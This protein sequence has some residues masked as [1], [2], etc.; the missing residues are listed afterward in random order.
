V[1]RIATP[2][3]D[4]GGLQGQIMVGDFMYSRYRLLMLAIVIVALTI[5][6]LLNKTSFGRVV[7]AGVQKPDM[8]AAL[9]IRLQPYM[10]AIVMLGV[11]LAALAGVLFA[12]ISG[13][14]PA[15][16][17]EIMTAAFVVVVIGGLGSFWGVVL[18]AVL[19][20]VVR[21]ITIQFYAPAGEASMYLLMLLVISVR[22][23]CWASASN[24]SNETAAMNPML[25]MN[26]NHQS[27]WIGAAALI[28]TPLL[29]PLLG[30]T[31]TSATDVVIYAIA[32]MG[33]NLLVGYTG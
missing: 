15:M 6:L 19:V 8:V 33:L 12:P 16:G 21:G 30:L 20:G 3:F 13:V 11:G 7:R 4:P 24:A 25:S 28:I 14:Q 29:L 1:G 9:G 32:A 23:A 17:A 2:G 26:P 10:T 18:A 31:T 5:W 27:L 22:A